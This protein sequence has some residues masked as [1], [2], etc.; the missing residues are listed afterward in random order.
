MPND[1]SS[2]PEMLLR[3]FVL[4]VMS[5]SLFSSV[6]H[7]GSRPIVDLSLEVTVTPVPFIPGGRGEVTLVLR[8]AGPE[9]AGATLPNQDSLAVLE[10]PFVITTQP[11]PFF[12]LKQGVGCIVDTFVSEIMDDGN[13]ILQYWFSFDAIGPGESRTCVYGIDFLPSTRHDFQTGWSIH[14]PNDEDINPANG[15]V[16]YV[17]RAPIAQVPALSPANIFALMAS[18]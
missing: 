6:S 10:D 13:Y 7:A 2:F 5:A 8:N 12:I 14:S 15:R 16:D 9:A 18:A 4:S 3:T 1:R 11:P 17:F